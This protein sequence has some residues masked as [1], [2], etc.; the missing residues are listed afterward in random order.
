MERLA[1]EAFVLHWNGKYK[2]WHHRPLHGQQGV[3]Q[4]ATWGRPP[5]WKTAVAAS[6]WWKYDVGAEAL[7]QC[8]IKDLSI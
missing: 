8:G 4:G 5:R 3:V 2:P 7:R 6:E 1:A